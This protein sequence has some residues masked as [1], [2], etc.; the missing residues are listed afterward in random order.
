MLKLDSR[1]R[2]T[3]PW[4]GCPR[5]VNRAARAAVAPAA[6]PRAPSPSRVREQA[7]GGGP[8]RPGRDRGRHARPPETAWRREEGGKGEQVGKGNEAGERRRS[9]RRGAAAWAPGRL[10]CLNREFF[11][12]MNKESGEEKQIQLERERVDGPFSCI[13]PVWFGKICSASE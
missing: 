10:R 9:G 12:T 13:G 1:D 3:S 5:L 7:T 2:S 6:D 8:A 11:F 4:H